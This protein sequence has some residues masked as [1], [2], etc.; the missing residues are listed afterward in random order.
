[1]KSSSWPGINFVPQAAQVMRPGS[2]A[3]ASIIHLT[4]GIH[5]QTHT[6][7]ELDNRGQRTLVNEHVIIACKL[8]TWTCT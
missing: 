3:L 2:V 4:A 6:H 7:A 1:M 8:C 5:I